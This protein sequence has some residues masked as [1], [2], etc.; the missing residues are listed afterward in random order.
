VRRL[1]SEFSEGEAETAP[2]IAVSVVGIGAS[3]IVAVVIG[4]V[5]LAIYLA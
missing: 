5:V 4:L 1:S 3:L 2:L